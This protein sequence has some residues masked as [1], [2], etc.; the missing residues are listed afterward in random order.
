MAWQRIGR[1]EMR[2]SERERA[3]IKINRDKLV[4]LE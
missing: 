3:G 4:A 1:E 2:L